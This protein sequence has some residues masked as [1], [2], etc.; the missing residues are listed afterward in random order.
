MKELLSFS[1][2]MVGVLSYSTIVS[3]FLVA[4]SYNCTL[5]CFIMGCVEYHKC[6]NFLSRLFG[7]NAFFTFF[8]FF[9]KLTLKYMPR[10]NGHSAN[11]GSS[12]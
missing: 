7:K 6:S 11:H 5:Y 10:Y 8:V 4:V 1:A 3:L 12:C 2:V 9:V